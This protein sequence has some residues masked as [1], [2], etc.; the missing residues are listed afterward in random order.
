MKSTSKGLIGVITLFAILILAISL[1]II[2]DATTAGGGCCGNNEQKISGVPNSYS[3]ITA[4]GKVFNIQ[5]GDLNKLRLRP[6]ILNEH[7]ESSRMI[8]STVTSD[9][10]VGQ[11]F[12]P[13]QDNI[14]GIILTMQSGDS[15]E[16]DDFENYSN[17][18]QLQA[19]WVETNAEKPAELEDNIVYEG[20]QSMMLKADGND[21]DEWARSFPSFDFT[22]WTGTFY[23]YNNHEYKDCKMR[24]FVEDSTGD[25]S[26]G[27]LVNQ[28][29]DTWEF[30]SIPVASL[31]PDVGGA[32]D[33]TDII[34][35]GYRVEEKD[36]GCK[37][38]FDNLV[39]FQPP[40]T[41]LIELWDM[42]PTLP[43]NGT[44]SISD[45]TQYTT[46]GDAGI[47]GIQA[48]NYTFE[49]ISGIRS[50]N[51]FEFVAGVALEIPGNV[52]L[53]T[54]NYHAII[55][56]H[57]NGTINVY[58]PVAAWD[59][60]YKSGYSFNAKNK[61][62]P[63]NAT[64]TD[65]DIMFGIYSTQDVY[66]SKFI[67]VIDAVPNGQSETTLYIEDSNM[68]RESVIISGTKAQ[69][70]VEQDI[71]LPYY[72]EKGSK[73]EQEYND[74]FTDN[75]SEISLVIQYYYIPEPVNG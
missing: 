39:S 8:I 11:I 7:A 17:D 70:F 52:I 29:K 46:L 61:T 19:V 16:F 36:G 41:V 42:G 15:V 4:S 5:K 68:Y 14:N 56:R 21:G 55:L 50:Y 57:L 38:Y 22:D 69:Q 49:L 18:A 64:G 51:I 44:T 32:A 43:V 48:A 73:F 62:S 34:K 31:T 47:S 72:M 6:Q 65:E 27:A 35:I 71:P 26:S 45:G 58:G 30:Y 25:T 20:N 3:K 74:D 28:N 40:G 9:N 54:S 10:I 63:I 37:M 2:S 60:Y 59:D 23:M 53:N 67:Q 1:G 66:F 12:K 24:V 13:S 33:L 75:V